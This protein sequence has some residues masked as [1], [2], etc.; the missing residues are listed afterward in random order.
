MEQP[1][2]VC[3]RRLLIQRGFAFTHR[4]CSVDSSLR[5]ELETGYSV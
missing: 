2:E 1:R 5:S 3:H 4:G